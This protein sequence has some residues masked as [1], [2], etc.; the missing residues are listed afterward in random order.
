ML[1]LR[2]RISSK[3]KTS[4]LLPAKLL[5]DGIGCYWWRTTKSVKAH[6][7]HL[8]KTIYFSK[9]TLNFV[10][11]EKWMTQCNLNHYW[12]SM[13]CDLKIPIN[14]DHFVFWWVKSHQIWL[15]FLLRWWSMTLQMKIKRYHFRDARQ[16]W[17]KKKK[18]LHKY[19]NLGKKVQNRLKMYKSVDIWAS[20]KKK[21]FR[22]KIWKK[23]IFVN[24]IVTNRLQMNPILSKM[25]L[26]LK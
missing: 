8:K 7:T 16:F 10:T 19:V 22:I 6:N 20:K 3:L 14:F 13:K 11:A 12:W 5:L 26:F 25:L 4:K 23:G 17:G 18:N 2:F 15:Q 24:F 21:R 1:P 9:F